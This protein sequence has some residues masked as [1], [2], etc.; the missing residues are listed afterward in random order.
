M[1]VTAFGFFRMDDFAN[2]FNDGLACGDVLHGEHPLPCT[3]ERRV[4]MRLPGL[5]DEGRDVLG[6]EISDNLNMYAH[7]HVRAH[8]RA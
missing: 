3:P 5:E 7:M 8:T 4:C 1:R 2:V 6:I